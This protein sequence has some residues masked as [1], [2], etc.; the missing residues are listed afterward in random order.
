MVGAGDGRLASGLDARSVGMDA[1][2]G[3]WEEDT[4]F[5]MPAVT[6]PWGRGTPDIGGGGREAVGCA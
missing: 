3:D 5:G 2:E 1:C 4:Q 6:L